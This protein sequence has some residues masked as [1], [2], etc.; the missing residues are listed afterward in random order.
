[1]VAEITRKETPLLL[2]LL[3]LLPPRLQDAMWKCGAVNPM[4]LL[5]L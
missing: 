3:L 2:D 1:M 4:L 5:E